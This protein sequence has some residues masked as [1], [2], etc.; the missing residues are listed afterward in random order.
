MHL[1]W[2]VLCIVFFWHCLCLHH[3]SYVTDYWIDHL[4][5]SV[6]TDQ[7]VHLV[8]L[9]PT[10]GWLSSSHFRDNPL[11][12]CWWALY[13]SVLLI[14]FLFWSL[15]F[16]NSLPLQLHISYPIIVPCVHAPPLSLCT[17]AVDTVHRNNIFLWVSMSW[18]DFFCLSKSEA[19]L[20]SLVLHNT[21][22]LL[23]FNSMPI[24]NLLNRSIDDQCWPNLQ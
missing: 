20:F 14:A 21:D 13:I 23:N 19:W 2:I 10:S 4:Y 9:L 24:V 3:F 15:W 8:C 6:W 11:P 12:I 7:S 5:G 17:T 18:L 1:H 16:C 22:S